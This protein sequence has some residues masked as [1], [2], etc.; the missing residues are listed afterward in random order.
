MTAKVLCLFFCMTSISHGFVSPTTSNKQPIRTFPVATWLD[1]L[2][3]DSEEKTLSVDDEVARLMRQAEMIRLQAEKMDLSLTLD[4]IRRIEAKLDNKRWLEKNPDKEIE[5]KTQLQSLNFRLQG[6]DE[7][8]EDRVI[9]K[10]NKEV[11]SQVA[12]T[13]ATS[14]ERKSLLSNQDSGANKRTLPEIPLAGFDDSDLELYIPIANDIYKMIPNA[15]IEEKLEAFRTAPELQA[16]FQQKIKSMLVEPL[17]EMQLLE[18][19]K[20]KYLDS[21]SSKERENLKR[22]I[23]RLETRVESDTFFVYSDSFYCEILEPLSKEEIALRMDAVGSLPDILISIYKQRNGLLEEDELRLAIEMDYYEPQLQLLGQAAFVDPFPDDMRESY[24]KGY[25]S[26]PSSV[27]DRFCVKNG[28]EIGID[29]E[30]VLKKLLDGRKPLSS[31]LEVAQAASSEPSE[32][33]DIDFVDRSR[34]LEEFYPAVGRMEGEHPSQVDVDKFSSEVLDKKM[35]MV[36]SK[37]ERVAGGYYIRGANL[38]LDDEDGRLTAADKLVA[39]VSKKLEASDLDLEFFYILDPSPP[40]D[41]ELEF[42]PVDKPLFVVTSKNPRK[43]YSLANPTTKTLT[44]ACGLLT[45]FFFSVGACALNPSI[46]DR[47]TATLESATS[48][49]VVDL[50]WLT[51]LFVPILLGTLGIQLSHELGHRLVAFKYKVLLSMFSVIIVNFSSD[52]NF[53][54]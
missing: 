10:P 24:I 27:Q 40:T 3:R 11:D 15:T 26:L 6:K 8:T 32:Y 41:E 14:L 39:Q 34:F 48:T 33:N 51:D 22:E 49:D 29:A 20:Q 35:F 17:E 38:L 50:Q 19:L 9:P 4:K 2:Q 7:A 47:F 36:T 37:P 1:A 13:D 21:S 18:S 44:T 54:L 53:V 52:L 42:G 45:T 5:L 16:H 12:S 31:L 25:N 46:S 30:Q 43:F 23:D 28:L